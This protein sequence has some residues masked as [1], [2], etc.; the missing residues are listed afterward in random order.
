MDI[1]RSVCCHRLSFVDLV[2]C[3]HCGKAFSAGMLQSQARAEDK[4]FNKKVYALFLAVFVVLAVVSIFI[5]S[6][7]VTSPP[8]ASRIEHVWNDYHEITL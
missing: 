1:T 6:Q 5:L 8:A 3:P 4:A 7:H 2:S